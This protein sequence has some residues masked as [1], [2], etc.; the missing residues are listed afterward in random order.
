MP[1]ETVQPVKF[2]PEAGAAVK[3]TETGVVTVSMQVVPQLILLIVI[4]S[5]IPVTVPL[6]TLVTVRM[7]VVWL[8]TAT[9]AEANAEPPGPVQV[10]VYV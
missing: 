8:D 6:P 5:P 4:G 1:A 2:E 10:K 3:V 9:F 7:F